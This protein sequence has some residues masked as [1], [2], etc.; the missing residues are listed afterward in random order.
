MKRSL[1]LLLGF[2]LS[3]AGPAQAKLLVAVSIAPQASFLDQIAG[4]RAEALVMVPA[5][6]DAHTYEPRPRQLAALS[7]ASLYCAVG[8]DFEAAWL[9]RF[10]AANPKMVLVHTDAG[11]EKIPMLAHEHEAHGHQ[12]AASGKEEGDRHHES[13]EPDPHVWLSP[14]L[15]KVLGANMRDALIQVDPEG[16]AAYR[17]GYDRFAATCDALDA[18]IHK[19]FADLPAGAHKFMVFHPS[20]GYFARDFGLTELP[21]EQL[22]REPG[23]KALAGLVK[24]AKEDGVKVIFVQPQMS[25]SQAETLAAAIGGTV[26]PL[27][28]LSGDW[29]GGLMAAAKALRQGL[30]GAGEAK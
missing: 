20:W 8:M 26:A 5:G 13:G 18:G 30:A 9:P 19:L 12:P 27:D 1:L 29:A 23:P 4:D 2:V 15:A 6:A 7:R 24:E 17:A 16:A 25:T 21:I 10:A 28:P 22:G 11:I 3:L 14:R